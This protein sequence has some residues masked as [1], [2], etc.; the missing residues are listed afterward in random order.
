MVSTLAG[1]GS[2]GYIDGPSYLAKFSDPSDM[3]D[4][5]FGNVFVV[6]SLNNRIRLIN[7]NTNQG[8]V[9]DFKLTWFFFL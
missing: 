4:D 5:G 8:L 9:F 6:D 7:I 2:L 1:A 3:C